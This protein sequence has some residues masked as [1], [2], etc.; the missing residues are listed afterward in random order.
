MWKLDDVVIGRSTCI[1][2]FTNELYGPN[3][4]QGEGV[5]NAKIKIDYFSNEGEVLN[6]ETPSAKYRN[7]LTKIQNTNLIFTSSTISI[8]HTKIPI[9][10]SNNTG[11][12][13]D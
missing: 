3:G 10:S 5:E 6:A 2:T 8:E 1:N 12:G 7:Y 9:K 4:A 11:T 13:N